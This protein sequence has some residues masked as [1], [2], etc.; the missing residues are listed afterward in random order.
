MYTVHILACFVVVYCQSVIH[1]LQPCI[2]RS[3]ALITV[4]KISAMA[5]KKTLIYYTSKNQKSYD[6]FYDI[7]AIRHV[8]G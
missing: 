4:G 6:S 2:Y 5:V 8:I 1:I 7:S 3:A